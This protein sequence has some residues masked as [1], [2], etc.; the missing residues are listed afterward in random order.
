MS[1]LRTR[2]AGG[3]G[4]LPP[5]ARLTGREET[6]II[7]VSMART[8]EEAHAYARGWFARAFQPRRWC[9]VLAQE[10]EL[11]PVEDADLL[12]ELGERDGWV[13]HGVEWI[14]EGDPRPAGS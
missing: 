7:E 6:T 14:G 4:W 10:A 3:E 8:P 12:R 13:A 9:F 1:G 11:D 2:L 5:G